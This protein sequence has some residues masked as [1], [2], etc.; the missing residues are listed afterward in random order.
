MDK[1]YLPEL[2]EEEIYKKWEGSGAFQPT[3]KGKPYTIIM[4]PPNAN[5]PL[6]VGHAMFVTIEDIFIRF[7]RMLGEAALWLPGTD[8]AGIETQ[9][10]FEKKLKKEGKSRFDFDRETLYQM[11][12]DYVQ[13]NSGTAI[14][15]MKKLGASADW[16]RTTFTLDKKIVDQVLDTFIKLHN[17]GLI[18]RGQRVVNYCTNCGTAFSNL[19]INHEE[20]I[21]P[22]YY[23]KYGPFTLATTRPETKFGDTAV[24]VNPKD[25]RYQKW[26]G[27][28]I[29]VEGLMGKF[30]IKVISDNYVDMKFGTGVVKITPA[31]DFNDYEV[32]QRHKNEIP[33][34]NQVIGFDGRLNEKTGKYQGLKIM[35]ARELI[36]EDLKKKG[37]IVK[38]EENY[39][40]TLAVC[41]RCG[42][43]IEPLPLPQFYLKV[44]PLTEKVL[45]ALKKG[46]VKIYGSG[47]DKI[48]KHWL[49]QLEDWNISR[50][51]VWGIRMPIWFKN[52]NKEDF[53]VSKTSPGKDYVQETDTFDTW[54]SSGQWPVVTLG[55]LF[56]KFYPTSLMETGYDILPFWVMRMLMLGIYMTGKVP[57]KKVYLHGLV[58]DEKGRKMS[59][60]K[61]NVMN[62]VEV[63]E[64]YGAD[65]L[66]MSLVMSTTAGRDSATGEGKIR[67]MR[68]L[69]NKI[70]N[71]ARYILSNPNNSNKDT[72]SLRKGVSLEKERPYFDH[73]KKVIA[74]VTKQL[75]DLKP[76]LGAETVYN[77][78]WHWFCDQKIEEAK[79]GKISQAALLDGLRI[80]LKLLH[81]FVPFVTEAVWQQLPETK[82]KLLITASW[83]K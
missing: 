38:I 63:I 58:R 19:E 13:E 28:E 60:S 47:H 83:P 44:K 18:Y 76:G 53:V 5:D 16:E 48:L 45:A 42:R 81:P 33:G 50:Q 41:Y 82:E 22:L 37:L 24:A 34:L 54:F 74:D 1:V 49:T 55:S 31:H 4:P 2:F 21:E 23:L 59:K 75:E 68:N 20:K 69:T 56:K 26:V 62:P 29:E 32:W 3:G 9:Y 71:A 10:V 43:T 66:R 51:I 14:K 35:A 8:H 78:F 67:G 17:D 52:G 70:W 61:G 46:E 27:K 64:K 36:V 39:Q 79:E 30:K 6:H 40:H 72:P 7:H 25:K 11:I 77:E 12:W 15:Q 65:A 73:L 57:F 80:F